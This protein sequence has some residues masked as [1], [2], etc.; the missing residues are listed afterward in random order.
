M[1]DE[2]PESSGLESEGGD[3]AKTAAERLRITNLEARS[4]SVGP[5]NTAVTRF[6]N[7]RAGQVTVSIDWAYGGYSNA[8]LSRQGDY[9]DIHCRT[10]APYDVYCWNTAGPCTPN[11]SLTCVGGRTYYVG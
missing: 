2:I 8:T 7:R 10:S 11:G 9:W 3:G 1:S 4:S 5:L 6:I